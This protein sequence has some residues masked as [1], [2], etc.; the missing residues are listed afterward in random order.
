MT[1]SVS[2]SKKLVMLPIKELDPI[3]VFESDEAKRTHNRSDS[4]HHQQA[5]VMEVNLESDLVPNCG[6]L[7]VVSQKLDG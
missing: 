5:R 6:G 1:R 3:F 2:H 7:T 4:I